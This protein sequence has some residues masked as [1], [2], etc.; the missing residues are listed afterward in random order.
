MQIAARVI[1]VLLGVIAFGIMARY[2]GQ[3]GFGWFTTTMAFLNF[4]G[5]FADFGLSL[6][7]IQLMSEKGYDPE[8]SF[9]NIFT[10][11]LMTGIFFLGVAPLI[12]L[13]FPYPIEIKIG[14]A[15]TT[16]SI[17][18]SSLIQ[19]YTVVYQVHL[20][21]LIPVIADIIG[22]VITI[23]GIM[24]GVLLNKGFFFILAVIAVNN[25][26]QVIMLHWYSGHY[27]RVR[28]ACDWQLWKDIFKRSWPIGL[29][30]IFN[31]IYLKADSV[32]LSFWRPQTEVG[33]YG[34]AYNVIQVLTAVP[35]LFI[36]LA[37][38]SYTA[39]WSQ[40][41]MP[42]FK[43]HVQKSFDFLILG[44]AP[45][46]VGT[47]FLARP[48]MVMIAGP[49]FEQSGDILKILILAVGAVFLSVLFGSLINVINKQRIMLIG[50]IAGAMIG[51]TGYI[52]TIPIY[53]YWG[54]AWVTVLSECS[55]LL[56]AFLIFYKKTRIAIS[57][58]LSGKALLASLAMALFLFF[59][60]GHIIFA[61]V[62]A[63]GIYACALIL[64]GGISKNDL[65]LFFKRPSA[66]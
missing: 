62:L 66:E 12:A 19:M 1:S 10:F 22:R 36:G 60:H 33:I 58:F 4:F 34:A 25:L 38:G 27:T 24:Y 30:I 13:F 63:G 45:L 43:A 8:K 54:A 61:I 11:R 6:V 46:I 26:V 5:I 47:L 37:L 65:I 50:Y 40:G 29:S 9:Q 39:S 57:L 32:F 55:I 7:A 41:D 48:I 52:L 20:N 31:I 15:I 51:V 49:S 59:F 21:M 35:F 3:E 14:I 28:L 23:A 42:R 18:F 16:S 56:F 64:L 44:A 53:S 2:L 17:L